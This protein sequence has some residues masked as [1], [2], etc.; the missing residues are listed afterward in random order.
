MMRHSLAL[1][2]GNCVRR[3]YEYSKRD[4]T[5]SLLMRQVQVRYGTGTVVV[6]VLAST[7]LRCER[8]QRWR[9]VLCLVISSSA[10]EDDTTIPHRCCGPS[11]ARRTYK[12]STGA[13]EHPAK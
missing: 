9:V 10:A 4:W 7:R 2:S 8:Q 6:R 13:V 5:T 12:Y 1:P 3:V 11:Q